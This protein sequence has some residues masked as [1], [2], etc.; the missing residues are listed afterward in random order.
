M[1]T[2]VLGTA[3]GA[4]VDDFLA[5]VSADTRINHFFL[6]ADMGKIKTGLVTLIGQATGGPEHYTGR[7]MKTTHAGLGIASADFDA[8]VEDLSR[9]LDKFKVPP[10]EKGEL[11]ALLGGMKGDIVEK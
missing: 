4:V 5:N 10:Q 9:S 6:D 7:D 1:R 3:I 2:L 8:L 11:L